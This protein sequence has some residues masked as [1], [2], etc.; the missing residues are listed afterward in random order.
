[1]SARHVLIVDDDPALL[2]ALPQ[3]LRLRMSD[4]VVDTAD[5]ARVALERIAERDY[6]A[7]VTDIKM[8]GMDGLTLL[9]EILARRPETPT[10]MVTG[11]GEYDLALRC[12]RGGA[13]DF[14][15]K[16]IDRESFVA[17]LHRAMQAHA[18]NR[19]L[20]ER[21]LALERCANEMEKLVLQLDGRQAR[22]LI[23]DDDPALLQALPQT[24]RL[25]MSGVIVETADSAMAALERI[26]VREYDAIVTDIKMPGM[27]G[28]TLLAEILARRPDTP[29]LMITG[30][31]D[32]DVALR[33]LRSGAYD[34]IQK[35]IDRDRFVASLHRAI[36]A[37][38]VK[39]REKDRSSALE[40]CVSELELIVVKLGRESQPAKGGP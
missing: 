24:L 33:S 39:R 15:Q 9:A 31:G 40:R 22:I 37:H 38:A 10:L 7:V 25:R 4:V 32:Y 36:E 26:A 11:H 35:P 1:V 23:I 29:T 20:K 6:D 28:L 3:T 2:Q 18:D 8:P 27:D 21:N 34:F 30:H 17:S 5:C 14:I 19:R 12:L 16:P 13:Y